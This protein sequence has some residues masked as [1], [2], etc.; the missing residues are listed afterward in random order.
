MIRHSLILFAS[1][2]VA[3][4]WPGTYSQSEVKLQLEA[5]LTGTL[6]VE[7]RT[8][9]VTARASGA[10]LKGDFS[11]EG[12]SFGFTAMFVGDELILSSGEA[13]YTLRRQGGGIRGDLL[14]AR[15]IASYCRRD[16]RRWRK[17]TARYCCRRELHLT[18]IPRTIRK[19]T[20]S[21]RGKVM[22]RARR[23]AWWGI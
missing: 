18:R 4:T 16:G 15:A 7:G 23:R 22:T 6:T 5:N 13:T 1:V 8:Y 12:H 21:R 11:A 19:H 17:P 2:L 20:S 10:M 14:T 9:P 3:Q